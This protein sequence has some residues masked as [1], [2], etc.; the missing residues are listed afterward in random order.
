[1][2][3]FP[4]LGEGTIDFPSLVATLRAADYQGPYSAEIEVE[5]GPSPE[6]QD[7]MRQRTYEF[8]TRLLR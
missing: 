8:M 3:D 6:E 1:M 4:L 2:Y 5:G 7:V